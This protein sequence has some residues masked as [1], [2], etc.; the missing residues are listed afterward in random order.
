MRCLIL[1]L[2]LLTTAARADDAKPFN[3]ADYPAGVQKAV[4]YANEACESQG[5]GA[6]TFAPDTVRKVDLTGDGSDDYIVDFRDTKCGERETTY[7]GT[8]GCVITILVT[9]ADGSVRPVFDGYVRGYTI[10]ARPMKRGASRTIRFDLHGSF[11][12]GFGAQACV[13][14]K[15]I[16]VTPFAFKQP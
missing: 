8:G 5:G 14:E 13:K 2:I 16:T 1:L 11:C 10:A 9:L 15:V 4:R 7:C 6:V 12:G 3:P